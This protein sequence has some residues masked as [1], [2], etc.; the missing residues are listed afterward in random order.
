M[1]LEK[2]IEFQLDAPFNLG[3]S[4]LIV[5]NS[6]PATFHRQ[7]SYKIHNVDTVSPF[8]QAWIV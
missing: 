4:S 7:V 1:Q 8:K 2:L 5:G 3:L 6:G